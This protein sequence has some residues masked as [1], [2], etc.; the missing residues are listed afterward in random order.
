M[1]FVMMSPLPRKPALLSP[2][3]IQTTSI[4]QSFSS[5]SWCLP[6]LYHTTSTLIFNCSLPVTFTML[7]NKMLLWI[8][9]IFHWHLVPISSKGEAQNLHWVSSHPSTS[10]STP[11]SALQILKQHSV[12]KCRMSE[13]PN[14]GTEITSCSVWKKTGSKR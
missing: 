8:Y 11:I 9:L 1:P 10:T 4:L 7:F 13:R 2:L 5:H 6:Y 12:N 3:P 14:K